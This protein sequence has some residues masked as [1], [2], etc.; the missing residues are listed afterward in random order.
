M[1]R[2]NDAAG[3]HRPAGSFQG[4]RNRLA[5]EYASGPVRPAPADELVRPLRL[6]LEQE[7]QFGN[8]AFGSWWRR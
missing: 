2:M 7:Y 6:K 4:L 3:F 5:S 8:D 1:Q